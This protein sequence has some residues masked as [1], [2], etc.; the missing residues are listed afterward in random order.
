V[1]IIPPIGPVTPGPAPIDATR[2]VR[3]PDTTGGAGFGDAMV[4]AL[5]SLDRSQRR[6][7]DLARAAATGDLQR[8]ED[9]MVASNETQLLT[10][11]TVAV[12]NRAVEAFNDIMRMQV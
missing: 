6:T 11:M 3:E 2:V 9:L 10:Q 1:T 8:V 4:G 7:D 5:D 12:R